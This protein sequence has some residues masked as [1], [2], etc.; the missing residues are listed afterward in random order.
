MVNNAGEKKISFL[1]KCM[2][3]IREYQPWPPNGHYKENGLRL[4]MLSNV[5]SG[6]H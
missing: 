5:C 1:R 4:K 3:D 6:E 2:C